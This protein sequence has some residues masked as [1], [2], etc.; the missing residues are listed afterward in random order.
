MVAEKGTPPRAGSPSLILLHGHDDDPDA[1]AEMAARIAPP[2]WVTHTPEGPVTTESGRA[3]WTARED[4]SPHPQQVADAFARLDALIDELTDPERAG[5]GPLVIGGFSQG[6]AL[7]LAY[8]L[9]GDDRAIHGAFAISAW[10]PNLD[11]VVYLLAVVDSLPVF[12]AHGTEDEDVPVQQGRS[13]ARLLER[14]DALV[15]FV[16]LPVGHEVDPF[17]DDL[18]TWLRSLEAV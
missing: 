3:W 5:A 16:E 18:A 15:T 8:L 7:A 9:R 10:L 17:L 14:N 2:G 12:V 6:G 11:E 4:G 13:A 1:F